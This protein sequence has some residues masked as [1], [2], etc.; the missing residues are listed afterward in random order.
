[1][2]ASKITHHNE[3]RI[4]IE[5]PYNSEATSRL[6]QIPDTR[7]SRTLRTWHIPYTKEAFEK[8]KELFPDVEYTSPP[9]PL[10]KK[11]GEIAPQP[12][13]YLSRLRERRGE[14]VMKLAI[15]LLLKKYN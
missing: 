12:L 10:L 9:T 8:L 15:R 5:F 4:R 2:K 1:M 13:G 6:K 14:S 7:W 11:R 3:L